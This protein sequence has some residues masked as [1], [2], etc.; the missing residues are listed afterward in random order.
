MAT[1]ADGQRKAHWEKVW[2]EQDETATSWFQAAPD[3]S[4]EL[5]ARAGVRAVDAVIDVGGGASRLVDH[6][7]ERGFTDLSVLDVSAAGLARARQR[8]GERANGVNWIEADVTAFDPRRRYRLW[9]DRAVF[10]FLCDAADR[11]AYL[12]AMDAALAADGQ[13]VIATFAPDGPL[14]C[15][16]LNTLR[17]SAAA[18]AAELGPGWRLLEARNERHRTPAGREQR[19]GYCRFDRG[20]VSGA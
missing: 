3:V 16:G 1:L 17:Y 20:A 4:L 7:L 6:L 11:A 10:H 12:A 18:L 5:I 14:K 13:A 15:S 9:H 19:F 2:S 8:L